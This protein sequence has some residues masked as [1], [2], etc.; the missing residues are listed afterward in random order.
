[1]EENAKMVWDGR[2]KR[3]I[4][5]DY[6]TNR[7]DHTEMKN[8]LEVHE[9]RINSLGIRQAEVMTFLKSIVESQERNAVGLQKVQDI[10]NNGL[11]KDIMQAVKD[12][13]TEACESIDARLKPLEDFGWFRR[14]IT[15]FKDNL[16]WVFVTAVSII[17]LAVGG[18]DWIIKKIKGM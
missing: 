12:A 9:A 2:D 16:F 10:L 3:L 17:G 13:V 11:K 4:V 18:I 7:I 14:G 8:G 6:E 15:N 1:V 5:D